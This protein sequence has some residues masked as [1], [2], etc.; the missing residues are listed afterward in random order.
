M[1]RMGTRK[2]AENS[3]SFL[4]SSQNEDYGYSHSARHYYVS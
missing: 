4:G 3:V 2:F 1:C